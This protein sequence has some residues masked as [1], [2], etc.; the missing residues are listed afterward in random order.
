MVTTL[1]APPLHTQ[2]RWP[3]RSAAAAPDDTHPLLHTPRCGVMG[4]PHGSRQE[5][6]A[7]RR[8]KSCIGV[9]HRQHS[10][11][12]EGRPQAAAAQLTRRQWPARARPAGA[13]AGAA[14]AARQVHHRRWQ[15]LLPRAQRPARGERACVV[16]GRLR[17]VTC[18]AARARQ[19]RSRCVCTRQRRQGDEGQHS[20]LRARVCALMEDRADDFAPF[21][22]DG[23]SLA[24]H[25]GR[26]RREGVWAGHMELQARVRV[27]SSARRCVAHGVCVCARA[28]V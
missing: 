17:S 14:G 4:A 8:D 2:Q 24:D 27:C 26:M 13:A 19:P 10:R 22:E 20:D 9:G 28:C 11:Q 25:L 5:A 1:R 6:A 7:G 23:G 16:R 21:V 3:L 18:S 15:L 12:E